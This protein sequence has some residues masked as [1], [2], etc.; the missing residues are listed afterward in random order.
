MGALAMS[1]A[2]GD[3]GATH[4]EWRN[5]PTVL[6]IAFDS[7]KAWCPHSWA[8][9]SQLESSDAM[10]AL[11]IFTSHTNNPEPGG[12]QSG[13]KAV[14]CP[15]SEPSERVGVRVGV[16][17]VG[18][19]NQRLNGDGG[20]IDDSEQKEVPESGGE[21]VGLCVRGWWEQKARTRRVLI[22]KQSV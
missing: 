3:H 17:D 14:E 22:A 9:K 15:K 20:P 1:K 21:K 12:Y 6:L 10:P 2:F 16:L 13:T 8:V 5:H 7:E 19:V 4:A 11:K 18:R